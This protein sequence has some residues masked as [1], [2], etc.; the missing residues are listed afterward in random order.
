MGGVEVAH[1]D[2]SIIGAGISE[3]GAAFHPQRDCQTKNYAIR[4][5]RNAF[6]ETWDLFR[7]PEIHSDAEMYTRGYSFKPEVSSTSV[8]GCIIQ[9]DMMP[10]RAVAWLDGLLGAPVA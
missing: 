4:E 9:F 3:I 6:G 7:Y 8:L 2:A 5:G 10:N 1:F